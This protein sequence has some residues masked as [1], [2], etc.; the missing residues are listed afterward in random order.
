VKRTTADQRTARALAATYVLQRD[1]AE[2]EFAQLSAARAAV[3][4]TIT[5]PEKLTL[6][7]ADHA[8][9]RGAKK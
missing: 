6:S 8:A 4:K 2:T 5:H 1:G 3:H 7:K 9:A